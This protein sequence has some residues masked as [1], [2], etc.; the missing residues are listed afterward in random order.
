MQPQPTDLTAV[1]N[2]NNNNNNNNHPNETH[3][4]EP[5]EW[6]VQ[7]KVELSETGD[8]KSAAPIDCVVCGDKSSGKH[9]GVYTCEGIRWNSTFSVLFIFTFI[10][11]LF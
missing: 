11:L 9:Y 2:N 5:P 6:D 10:F 7:T 4:T 3:H 1:H 8:I